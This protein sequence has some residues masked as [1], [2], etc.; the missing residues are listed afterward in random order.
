MLSYLERLGIKRKRKKSSSLKKNNASAASAATSTATGIAQSGDTAVPMID[1]SQRLKL[2]EDHASR[3]IWVSSDEVILL[4]AFSPLYQPAYE[5]LVAIS[6]PQS[7]PQYIHKYLLTPNSLYAA[8]SVNI[9]TD[10]IINVLKRLSKTDL[11]D[12]VVQFIREETSTFGKAKLV[13]KDNNFYVESAFPG[14]LR[15]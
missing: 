12:E 14:V 8:V 9:D 10:T 7:R 3:P 1:L 6:E 4:E 11:P 2:K 5:F 13:L 15:M